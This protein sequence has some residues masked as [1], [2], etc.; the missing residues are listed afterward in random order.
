MMLLLVEA[1]RPHPQAFLDQTTCRRLT[2]SR[3]LLAQSLILTYNLSTWSWLLL[4]DSS[5]KSVSLVQFRAFSLL[6]SKVTAFSGSCL[7]LRSPSPSLIKYNLKLFWKL[8]RQLPSQNTVFPPSQLHPTW[9]QHVWSL[10]GLSKMAGPK[11]LSMASSMQTV[12]QLFLFLL[13]GPQSPTRRTE[14]NIACTSNLFSVIPRD[15][16]S[17]LVFCCFLVKAS[18]GPA[19]MSRKG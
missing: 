19:W 17:L 12:I 7:S 2:T 18:S 5:S 13:P 11:A 10:K 8:S 3:P 9:H 1:R 6:L 4:R 15:V 14:E 16:K